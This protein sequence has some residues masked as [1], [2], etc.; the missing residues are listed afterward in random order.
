MTTPNTEHARELLAELMEVEPGKAPW[1]WVESSNRGLGS[2]MEASGYPVHGCGTCGDNQRPFESF[3]GRLI[4]HMVNNAAEYIAAVEAVERVRA[5]HKKA[6]SLNRPLCRHC[7][8]PFPCPTIQALEF[9]NSYGPFE[10][11]EE[12]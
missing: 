6:P 1:E 11:Q 5:L 4:V 7:A 3:Q 8:A 9:I 12:A 10:I 2:I